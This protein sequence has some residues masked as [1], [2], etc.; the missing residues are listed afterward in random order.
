MSSQSVVR[1]CSKQKEQPRSCLTKS[2]SILRSF[3]NKSHKFQHP[4][5]IWEVIFIKTQ[6]ANLNSLNSQGKD[7]LPYHDHRITEPS[8]IINRKFKTPGP[9]QYNPVRKESVPRVART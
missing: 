9:G 6:E 2:R 3:R 1:C 4:H 5:T 8:E 7:T